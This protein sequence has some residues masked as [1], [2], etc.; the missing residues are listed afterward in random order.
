VVERCFTPDP[1]GLADPTAED[2]AATGMALAFMEME[3]MGKGRKPGDVPARRGVK[4]ETEVVSQRRS[5]GGEHGPASRYEHGAKSE[6][7]GRVAEA[8]RQGTGLR[9][10]P[11]RSGLERRTPALHRGEGTPRPPLRKGGT[12]E[13]RPS[14]DPPPLAKGGRGG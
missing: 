7:V 4:E 14:E 10:F 2:E 6:S 8:D 3:S 13:R 1:A 9:S 11:P 5:A 12:E